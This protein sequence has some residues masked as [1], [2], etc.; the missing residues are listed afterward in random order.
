[1][2]IVSLK[3]ARSTCV[4][5]FERTRSSS[6]ATVTLRR[7]KRCVLRVRRASWS[8]FSIKRDNRSLSL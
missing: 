5:T 7:S 8:T 2:R 1:L 6:S 3:P 4:A